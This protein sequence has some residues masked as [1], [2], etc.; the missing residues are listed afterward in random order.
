MEYVR[1]F[2]L[3]QYL[4]FIFYLAI[5]TIGLSVTPVFNSSKA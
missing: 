5:P 3:N 1:L 2:I 4:D